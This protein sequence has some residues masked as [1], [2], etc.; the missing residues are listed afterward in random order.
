VFFLSKPPEGEIRAFLLAQE[1]SPLSYPEVGA[2]R[3]RAPVGY[4]VDHNRVRLGEGPKV[5]ER[6][7]SAIRQWKMFAMPWLKL[8]WPDA[9]IKAGATVAV[10]AAHFG[11]WSLN[12]CRIVY[13]LGT[14]TNA[15][16]YGFA[17]GTL[18]GHAE[19]GEER[20]S[21]EFH[22]EDGAV[23]YDLYSFSRP[24]G[25]ARLAYPFSR[26]LQRRFIR[27]SKNAMCK[28]VEES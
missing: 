23:W 10:L 2:T 28:F 13:E 4:N 9:P 16:K 14:G 22:E 18:T 21:V 26:A 11:F 5:F 1:D 8:C 7:V 19:V 12:A 17:Y 24:T 27:D 6:A 3:D 25:L 15:D 20:F